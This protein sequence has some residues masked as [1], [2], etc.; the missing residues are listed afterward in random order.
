M[1][2]GYS[3]FGGTPSTPPRSSQPST[4]TTQTPGRSQPG[5]AL[6]PPTPGSAWSIVTV[7]P[8]GTAAGDAGN[9][10]PELVTYT[11]IS[12]EYASLR[13]PGHCPLGMYL[14][15]DKDS[16]FVWDGVFF[17]HQGS[18]LTR[19][20]CNRRRADAPSF[21]F[22]FHSALPG[23]HVRLRPITV[24]PTIARVVKAITRIA[25]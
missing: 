7:T 17:V 13:Y 6:L 23:T 25:S 9:G 1:I 19:T 20:F 3:T 2:Y 21:S 15:P 10:G 16:M 8:A 18:S 24:L 4:S 22:C 11:A 5:S 12:Q 14:I